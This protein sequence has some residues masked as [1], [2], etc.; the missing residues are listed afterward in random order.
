VSLLSRKTLYALDAV[1]DIAYNARPDPVQSKDIA[2]RQGIPQRYLEAAMQRL[3]RAGVLRGVRGPRGGYRLARERRRISV[4]EVVRLLTEFEA[5]EETA[6]AG[7]GS[8]LGRRVVYPR[9]Q[10]AEEEMLQHLDQL[11]IED[12]C[13]EAQ[14]AG[15]SGVAERADFTI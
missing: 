1:V 11:S 8:E 6:E 10:A 13:R 4:G 9:L 15:L 5:G 2:R 14:A 12:L 3:V 7:Q